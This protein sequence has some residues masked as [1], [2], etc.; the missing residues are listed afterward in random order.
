MRALDRA[1]TLTLTLAVALLVPGPATAVGNFESVS[2]RLERNLSDGDAEVVFEATSGAAGLLEL[3]VIAPD[4]RVV[5]DFKAP[6]TRHGI[7]RF[8]LESPEPRDLLAL[9][10][11]FPAGKYTF[12]GRTVA[13]TPLSGAATLSH[14]LPARVVLNQPAAE[15]VGVP[16]ERLVVEWAPGKQ[17]AHLAAC[18]VA[19]EH[20][21][22]G[23]KLIQAT[24][25]GTATRMAVPDRL[26]LPGTRYKIS[27]GAVLAHGNASF[28]ESAFTTALK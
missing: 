20:E 18:I 3:K 5:V 26:L 25:P 14:Q 22:S 17:S 10:R 28:V 11:D 7:R 21:R 6:Q 4:A 9:Q 8:S 19:I 27:V 1:L 16:L 23:A 12:T 2:V 15:A 24:L 13:G